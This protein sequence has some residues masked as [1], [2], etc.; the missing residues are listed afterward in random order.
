MVL[1][2]SLFVRK[3]LVQVVKEVVVV[4]CVGVVVVNH[5]HT[6]AHTR[7]HICTVARTHTP[8]L[9]PHPHTLLTFHK[10]LF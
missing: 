2:I 9:P 5:A 10:L 4:V 8:H 1:Y 3:G 7:T 6:Q